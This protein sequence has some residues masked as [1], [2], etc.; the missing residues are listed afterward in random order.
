[1][2]MKRSNVILGLAVVLAFAAGSRAQTGSAREPIARIEEQ[3]IYEEDLMPSMG[4]QLLQFRN[5]EYEVKVNALNI[6][7][8]ERLLENE[9]KRNGLSTIAF[10]EHTLDRRVTTRS[11]IEIESYS[12]AQR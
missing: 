2:Q 5:Q 1:M 7:L 9:A 10:L 6:V 11:S 8:K 4:A 3:A 12:G